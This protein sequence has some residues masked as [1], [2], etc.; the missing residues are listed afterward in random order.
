[1]HLANL[2]V[3]QEGFT[4][5]SLLLPFQMQQLH[6]S[7][8]IGMRATIKREVAMRL[9]PVVQQP[10]GSGTSADLRWPHESCKSKGGR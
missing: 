4:C 2:S 7:S 3:A 10:R 6:T 5:Q 9:G 8:E 1:V